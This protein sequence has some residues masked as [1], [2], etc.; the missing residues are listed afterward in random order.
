MAKN[1]K[2]AWFASVSTENS[3]VS[4]ANCTVLVSSRSS[5]RWRSR[6]ASRIAPGWWSYSWVAESIGQAP[7]RLARCGQVIQFSNSAR[8][9][10]TPRG[11]FSA[12]RKTAS[13][14][15]RAH[16]SRAAICRSSL[17]PKW[18]NR[19]LLDIPVFSASV[20]MVSDSNPAELACCT[21][22]VRIGAKLERRLGPSHH[23]RDRVAGRGEVLGKAAQ[24]LDAVGGNAHLLFGFAQCRALR[25]A[26]GLVAAPARKADLPRVVGEIGGPLREHHGRLPPMGHHQQQHRRGLERRPGIHLLPLPGV[27]G[28]QLL[29]RRAPRPAPR[30]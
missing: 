18:A 19:P 12:G 29:E 20:P 22:A 28:E 10:F 14:N 24:D 23:G 15:W 11:A 2:A 8:R 21:A 3:P 25:T 4:I 6:T 17:E 13:V 30:A 5:R 1:S 16:S 7:G 27:R 26:I 9:R